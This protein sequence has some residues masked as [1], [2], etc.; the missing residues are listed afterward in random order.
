[1]KEVLNVTMTFSKYIRKIRRDLD[2]SQK[3]M[4]KELNVSFASINRWENKQ[5]SPSNLARKSFINFC[6]AR[7]IPIPSELLLSER[8]QEG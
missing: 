8:G 6:T 2:M 1:M 3:E 5:V 4:A 7:K